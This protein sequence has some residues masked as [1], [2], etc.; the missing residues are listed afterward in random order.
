VKINLINIQKKFSYHSESSFKH[1]LH[2]KHSF[3]FLSS[4][5]RINIIFVLFKLHTHTHTNSYGRNVVALCLLSWYFDQKPFSHFIVLQTKAS[6]HLCLKMTWKGMRKKSSRH[7]SFKS[8]SQ[9]V[10]GKAY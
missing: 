6:S 4:S 10:G 3:S 8:V 1:S 5:F 2:D 9:S 7:H